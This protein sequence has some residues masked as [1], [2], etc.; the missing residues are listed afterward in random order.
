MGFSLIYTFVILQG[1]AGEWDDSGGS[2]EPPWP[3]RVSSPWPHVRFPHCLFQLHCD[4]CI[5]SLAM[6]LRLTVAKTPKPLWIQACS[7]IRGGECWLKKKLT[8]DNQK[9]NELWIT[10]LNVW[11]QMEN[12][13]SL[14][15]TERRSWP[16][17]RKTFIKRNNNKA[18]HC[19]LRLV[20]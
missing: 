7:V 2:H 6:T 19:E 16:S 11:Q 4:P 10:H 12:L 15:H 13:Q 5:I 17:A 20:G 8:W 3:G 9:G 1:S 14:L 18:H